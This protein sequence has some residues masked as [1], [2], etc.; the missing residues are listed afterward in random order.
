MYL[1]ENITRFIVF[2]CIFAAENKA[3]RI[4][5]AVQLNVQILRDMSEIADSDYLMKMLAKYLKKLVAKKHDEALMTEEEFFA[6]V[7]KARM[8]KSKEF[9]NVDELDKF[10]R[11]L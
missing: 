9:D 11:N 3:N 7:D 6:R 4:M 1:F 8:G 10:I 2:F 5:T